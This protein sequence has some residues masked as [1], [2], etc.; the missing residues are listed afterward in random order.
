MKITKNVLASLAIGIIATSGNALAANPPWVGTA[1][2]KLA[3]GATGDED[4]VGPFSTYDLAANSPVLIQGLN[5]S[6]PL[7]PQLGNSFQGYYQS[8]VSQHQLG[9]LGVASPNLN[10][11]GA[12]G[13]GAGY[14][15]TIVTDFQETITSATSGGF[16]FDITGGSTKLYFDTTPDYNFIGDSGFTDVITSAILTGTV[17]GGQGTF[18]NSGGFGFTTLDVKIDSFDSNVFDPDTIAGGDGIFTLRLDPTGGSSSGI[19][20]VQNHVRGANDVLLMAD[21]NVALTVP[22]VSTYMMMLM[23]VG[24]VGFMAVRRRRNT[25]AS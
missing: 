15:L 4:K 7:A 16:N 17:T 25:F 8:Y 21:G 10:T 2:Y 1:D 24:M 11:L 13:S 14:E 20:S 5:G 12:S 19:T 3:P 6:N 18:L 9:T 22:E 23:G